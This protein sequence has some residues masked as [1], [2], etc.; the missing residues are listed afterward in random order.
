M[1]IEVVSIV[2]C[3]FVV[4][5]GGKNWCEK[6]GNKIKTMLKEIRVLKGVK[7]VIRSILFWIW[8]TNEH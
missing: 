1:I 7:Y 6:N 5:N 3:Y 4:K 2:I 8:F